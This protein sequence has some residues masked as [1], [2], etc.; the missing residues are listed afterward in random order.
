MSARQP[1]SWR[2][3]LVPALLAFAALVALGTWQMQRKAWKEGLIAAL[4]ERLAAS[5]QKLPAAKK[6]VY[7]RLAD[8]RFHPKVAKV[9]PFAQAVG[10]TN[11]S[12]RIRKRGKIVITVP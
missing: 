12:N 1:R 4:T 6:C 9:F 11:I 2:G 3:L 7:D 8:G 5:P 10:A